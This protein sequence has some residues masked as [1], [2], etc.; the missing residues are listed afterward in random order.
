MLKMA[1]FFLV[2]SIIAAL[3]GFGGISDAA[4]GMAKILFFIAIVLFVVFLV[5]ALLAGRTI[6]R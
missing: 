4:A 6:M 5:V 1:L 2:I 3:F